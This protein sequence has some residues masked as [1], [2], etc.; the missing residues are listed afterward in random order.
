M[1]GRQQIASLQIQLF[2]KLKIRVTFMISSAKSG[3][4][5]LVLVSAKSTLQKKK[6][7]ALQ[8]SEGRAF[9]KVG[10]DVINK[11]LHHLHIKKIFNLTL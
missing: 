8:L 5:K 7:S 9:E 6:T 1:E 2:R 3:V 4:S 10:R 11:L